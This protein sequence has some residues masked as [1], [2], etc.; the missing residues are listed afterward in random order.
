[1]TRATTR[2][3]REVKHTESAT[4]ISVGYPVFGE[5]QLRRPGR[6]IGRT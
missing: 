1:M 5:L 3:Q 4:E 2:R 6:A